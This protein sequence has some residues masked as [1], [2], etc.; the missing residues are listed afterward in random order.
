MTRTSIPKLHSIKYKHEGLNARNVEI[1]PDKYD[2]VRVL[3]DK[4]QDAIDSYGYNLSSAEVVG[5]LEYVKR[6]LLS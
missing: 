5:T 1:H 2:Y 3:Q 4:I 6:D